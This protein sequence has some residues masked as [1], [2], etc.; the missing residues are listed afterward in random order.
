MHQVDEI[1]IFIFLILQL[2]EIYYFS[3]RIKPNIAWTNHLGAKFPLRKIISRIEIMILFF[4][5]DEVQD[6]IRSAGAAYGPEKQPRLFL[7]FLRQRL[8]LAIHLVCSGPKAMRHVGW[9]GGSILRINVHQ[10]AVTNILWW[11]Q[12]GD[13]IDITFLTKKLPHNVTLQNLKTIILEY[14]Y[15]ATTY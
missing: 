1:F 4:S 2:L 3:L 12:L 10:K 7:S 15:W 13:T 8:S 14:Q 9:T 6:R 5:L 11:H